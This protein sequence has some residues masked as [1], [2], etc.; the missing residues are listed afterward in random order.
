MRNLLQLIIRYHFFILFL[1]LE[2]LSFLFVIRYNHFQRASFNSFA[3]S[4]EGYVYDRFGGLKAY[5]D[6]RT[7]NQNLEREN[8]VLLNEIDRLGRITANPDQQTTESTGRRQF[9]YRSAKVINNSVNRPFNFITVDKG[10]MHGI[11]PEMAVISSEGVV[12]IVFSVSRHFSTVLPVLNQNFGLSSKLKKNNYFGSLHWTGSAVDVAELSAIPGHVDVSLGDTIVTS[13]YSSIFPA[14]VLIGT[15]SEINT[16]DPSFHTIKV[17]LSVNF[18]KL[19]YVNI[20]E[21]LLLEEQ[22]N[23]ENTQSDD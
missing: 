16:E 21:N 7:I 20:I 14:D 5:L 8:N 13:G 12:G 9:L 15:V 3:T 11:K 4:V 1:L 10:S 17:K 19:A 6:L 2:V 23:L 22:L 18:R